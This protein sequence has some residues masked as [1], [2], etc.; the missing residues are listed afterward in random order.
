MRPI[1]GVDDDF[2]CPAFCRV[3]TNDDSAAIS[4]LHDG[5]VAWLKRANPIWVD[6]SVIQLVVYVFVDVQHGLSH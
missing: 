6:G 2:K 4:Y 1:H 3:T 5:V